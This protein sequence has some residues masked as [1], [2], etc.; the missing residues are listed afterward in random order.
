MFNDVW[1][2]TRT[3]KIHLFEIIGN[4]RLYSEIDWVPYLF[5]KTSDPSDIKTI[6]GDFAKKVTFATYSDYYEHQKFNHNYLENA[7]RPEIQFL[8]ERYHKITDEE[9]KTGKLKIGFID[10]EVHITGKDFPKPSEAKEPVVLISVY[11]SKTNT[12]KS[13]GT[14]PYDGKYKDEPWYVYVFCKDEE[15]LLRQFFLYMHKERFDVISG[16]NVVNFDLQYLINRVERITGDDSMYKYLSPIKQLKM[17][18]KKDS[19]DVNVDIAGVNVLDFMELYKW[20][21]PTKRERYTLDFIAKSELSKGKVDYSVYNDLRQLY[22]DNW[23]LYVEYN[24]ID[25]YRVGQLEEKLGYIK[26]VQSLSLLAKVPMKYYKTQTTLIEGVVL[27]YLRRNNM[28]A[29]TFYGGV[30]ETFPAAWVKEP[31]KGFHKWVI[32]LDITSS[33]P[34]AIIAL[35]MSVETF[36]GRIQGIS[37]DQMVIYTKDRKYPEFNMMKDSGLIKF[38]GK[39]LLLFNKALEKGLFAIAPCGSVF[40]TKQNGLISSIERQVFD[41]RVSVKRKMNDLKKTLV[42]LSGDEL[43]LTKEN[44]ARYNSLQ[45]VLKLILNSM[46]GATATPYSRYFNVNISEAIVSVGRHTIKTANN[47]VNTLLNNPTKEMLDLFR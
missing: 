33:Y 10:I 6:E 30:Q 17:W 28:C 16:Y 19:D 27:T 15:M 25:A 47:I 36:Y 46:Y 40:S 35:N 13:F 26:L 20:Y 38:E 11:D 29:P 31:Q 34:S 43:A 42:T 1:Y 3:N 39:N 41:K 14:K 37:E 45:N 23:N 5:E 32:D 44:V 12:T 24:V 22:N 18:S 7:V 9:M 4:D 21:S 8:A 2:N